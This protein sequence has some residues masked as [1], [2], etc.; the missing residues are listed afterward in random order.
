MS[1]VEY[2]EEEAL[3]KVYDSK[4]MRRL[5][6]YA[7][8]YSGALILSVILLFV[9]AGAELLRPYL[10]KVAIDAYISNPYLVNAEKMQGVIRIGLIFL[11]VTTVGFVVNYFQVFILTQTGQ[12]IVF[13]IRQ[14]IF[15]HIEK[16]PLSYFDKNPIG[17]LVTRVTNDTETLNE[18]YTSILVNLVKDVLLV[19]G[20]IIGMLILHIHLGLV[21]MTVFP[22]IIG[23]ALLF[24]VKARE[25]YRQVRVKL[26][27]LNAILSENISG[28]KIVYIF[29][30]QK[31]KYREFENINREYYDAGLKEVTVYGIFRPALELVSAFGIALVIWYGGGN[32]VKGTLE[33]GVLY[34]FINYLYQIFQPINDLAEKYNILQSAMASSERI[35]QVLDQPHEHP[36][37]EKPERVERLK[38]DIRFENVWFAYNEDEWVLKDVSFTIRPG[39][40]VAF[41][42]HTGAGKTSIINLMGRFYE[43]QRGRI[44]IDGID[45][46]K[47]KKEELRKNMAVVLQDVFLFSGDVESNIRLNNQNISDEKI[48]EISQYVNVADFIE[49]LPGKYRHEVK[50]RGAT[51]SA[52]QRQLIAFARALAFDPPIL[53]LDEAT[54]N[55]DTETEL[56]IQDALKK[57]TK[58]RTTI[59]IAH[60]LSTIQHADNIIVLHHGRIKEMGTHQELLGKKGLYYDL[61]RLQGNNI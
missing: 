46:Q 55:I 35:F 25:A 5:L 45:I 30:R 41:V 31:E 42:G 20:S 53:V 13:D 48:Q 3:G 34:A 7:R 33:F 51:F 24:R 4:L 17:R 56:L 50:E 49:K 2:H 44:T 21:T 23:L 15:F 52:G 40:T 61:Y 32:V 11:G 18:M 37:I 38:G 39:Q 57:L 59:V 10:L 26:A 43:I 60:R 28:M 19:V 16:L 36:A 22:V 9:V 54:A 1:N 12:K 6:E 27:K 14:Q 47:M 8:P 58:E 29:N